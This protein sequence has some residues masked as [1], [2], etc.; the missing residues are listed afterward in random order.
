MTNISENENVLEAQKKD[1][2]WWIHPNL[3]GKAAL[4][5]GD[6]PGIPY[7]SY[8]WVNYSNNSEPEDASKQRALP[9]G[10]GNYAELAKVLYKLNSYRPGPVKG[11]YIVV[12]IEPNHAWAV[13]QMMA[14][15]FNPIRVFSDLVFK[16]EKEA[17]N[18]AEE[19]RMQ[20]KGGNNSN[21]ELVAGPL[22]KKMAADGIESERIFKSKLGGFSK[23]KKRPK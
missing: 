10:E 4:N 18:K 6:L 2:F 20:K 9:P 15:S 14:D 5:P 7:D 12:C 21:A 16:T 17:R 19:L 11:W 23:K 3:R 22:I 8:A 1:E 13:G